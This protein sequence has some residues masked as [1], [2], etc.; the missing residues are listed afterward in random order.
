MNKIFLILCLVFAYSCGPACDEIENGA[1]VIYNGFDIDDLMVYRSSKVVEDAWSD[2]IGPADFYNLATDYRLVIYFEDEETFGHDDWLGYFNWNGDLQGTPTIHIL[3]ADDF[4]DYNI[5]LLDWVLGHEILHF[6]DYLLA[7]ALPD[8]GD[9]RIW[10]L[11]NLLTEDIANTVE[12]V[13]YV[14][15]RERCD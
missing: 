8:H 14:A 10:A 13:V 11:N 7:D 2:K 4:N 5:C 1:C 6:F 12:Y 15:A 3:I 9:K